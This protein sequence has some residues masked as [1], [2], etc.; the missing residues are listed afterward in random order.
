M[1]SALF[2]RTVTLQLVQQRKQEE[3]KEKQ[4]MESRALQRA[5]R[6]KLKQASL[7]KLQEAWTAQAHTALSKPNSGGKRGRGRSQET[8]QAPEY[9]TDESGD[10]A[11]VPTNEHDDD[12]GLADRYA[13]DPI[14][15][16]KELQ[17]PVRQGNLKDIGLSSSDDSDDDPFGSGEQEEDG[18]EKAAEENRSGQK[19]K[20][21]S[22]DGGTVED[23]D[24]ALRVA[25]RSAVP[26]DFS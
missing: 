24:D 2:H 6:A 1:A 15:T 18:Q 23:D 14:S 21:D 3:E 25:G 17:P 8:D 12:S 4:R 16:E 22:D 19:R 11:N 20:R 13:D 10:E 9:D 5:E 26:D 7:T